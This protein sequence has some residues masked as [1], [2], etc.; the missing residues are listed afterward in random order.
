M[1]N[2]PHKEDAPMVQQLAHIGIMS[3]SITH[4]FYPY[5]DPELYVCES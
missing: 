5:H 3:L 4:K 1:A 2:P